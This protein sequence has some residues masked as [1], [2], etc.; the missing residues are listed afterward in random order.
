METGS[1]ALYGKKIW[2]R[3]VYLF[4]FLVV[5]LMAF[6]ILGISIVHTTGAYSGPYPTKAV[7]SGGKRLTMTPTVS[8]TPSP[9]PVVGS[10]YYL[11]YPGMLPDH[12]LYPVKMIRDWWK[13]AFTFNKISRTKLFLLYAD[14][15]INAARF[16]MEG[17]KASLGV[18]TATKAEKYLER[19]M[20]ELS[21]SKEKNIEEWKILMSAAVKH[22]EML[23]ELADKVPVELR[24]EWAKAVEYAKRVKDSAFQK[25]QETK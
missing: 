21:K 13:Q 24:G 12:F 5:F 23:K 7:K 10:T 14:K 18:S 9:T 3:L 6:V 2:R 19:A 1:S 11:P 17:N 15:R 20:N 22:E 8:V 16:L 25:L 4:G